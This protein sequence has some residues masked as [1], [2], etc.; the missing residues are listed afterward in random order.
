MLKQLT[1]LLLITICIS[2]R[3]Q[4][5]GYNTTDVGGEFQFTPDYTSYNLLLGFNAKLHSAVIV[6]GGYS[7]SF[8]KHKNA[9]SSE[10]GNGW[11]ASVGFRYHFSVVPKRFFLGINAG[12]QSFNIKWAT[13]GASG[14]SKILVLQPRLDAGYTFLINDMFYITPQLS[15]TVQKTL[16]TSGEPVSFGKDFLGGAGISAGWRF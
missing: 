1:T 11:N 12:I 9:A 8:V 5:V 4:E 7:S 2:A 6:R 10:S 3:S 15:A 13:T 16:S 14:N